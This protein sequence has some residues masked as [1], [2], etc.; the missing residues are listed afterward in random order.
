MIGAEEIVLNKATPGINKED[1]AFKG[2]RVQVKVVASKIFQV[3]LNHRNIQMSTVNMISEFL[4]ASFIKTE[5]QS[6]SILHPK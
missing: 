2:F 3:T 5:A 4:T 1:K 6:L